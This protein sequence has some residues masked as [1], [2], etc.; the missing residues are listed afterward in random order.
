[1]VSL[2]VLTSTRS[3]LPTASLLNRRCLTCVK[4]L[5][6]RLIGR[7]IAGAITWS[8]ERGSAMEAEAVSWYE[9]MTDLETKPVGFVTDDDMQY[10]ASPDR[11]VGDDGLLEIKCPVEHTH[12]GYMIHKA[13]DKKYQPQLQGQLLVT[14]RK[15]VEI[16]SYHPEM[17]QA[18]IR[19]ERDEEYI[20]LLRK[21]VTL[22]S[23]KL[24]KTYQELLEKY[25][26][27][28]K[29]ERKPVNGDFGGLGV[30]LSDL[31]Y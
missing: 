22:F 10:G 27:Q 6:E 15:W 26:V 28:P 17:P 5:A 7:P 21:A 31:E 1:M 2:R 18:F 23:A 24:E 8:M 4:L 9:L 14:G 13:I 11:L 12:V 25:D 3:L 30:S 20:E 19:A 29:P 16:L